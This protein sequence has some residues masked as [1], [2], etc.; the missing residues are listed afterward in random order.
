[1]ER[2]RFIVF[3]GIGGS[4]K[5]TQIEIAGKLLENKGFK[6]ITTRE[7][8]GIEPA[9]KIRQLIFDLRGKEL[10]GAEG[11]MALFFAARKLWV[12]GVVGPNLE[13]GI[14]VL[15]D[16][17]HTS[18][19][20]Y[21]GYAEGGDLNKILSIS[22]VVLGKYKPDAVIFLD[23]SYDTMA[24]R[25]GVNPDGDPFDLQPREYVERL[26]AGYR[27]MARENWGGMKWFVVDGEGTVDEVASSV[28]KVLEQIF[29]V[30]LST[31][32]VD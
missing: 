29:S 26:I 21:Q 2:G 25:R 13:K 30:S 9:E 6:V 16:R 31:S 7:P 22:E 19:A 32:D 23:I 8:G 20:A 28:A 1:M 17:C 12:D 18:T 3:E 14:N 11:Q 24:K 5:G 4:G 27:K 10:I 15:T